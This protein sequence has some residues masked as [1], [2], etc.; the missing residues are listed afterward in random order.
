MQCDI[1]GAV[2]KDSSKCVFAR[3]G[4]RRHQSRFLEKNTAYVDLKAPMAPRSEAFY[5]AK[6]DSR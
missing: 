4:Q 5:R 1:N 6:G 2:I 3:A